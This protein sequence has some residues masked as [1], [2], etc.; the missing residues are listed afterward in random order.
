VSP[1]EN[2]RRS[3]AF[4]KLLGTAPN[5]GTITILITH[6][7]NIVDAL[8]K[9]WFD[10]REGEASIFRPQNGTYTLVARMQMGEWPR[11]SAAAK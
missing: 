8:G 7:P 11:I 1:N 4:R 2:N 10:V 9:D 3:E 6:K 5:P